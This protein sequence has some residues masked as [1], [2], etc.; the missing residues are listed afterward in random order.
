MLISHCRRR[1]AARCPTPPKLSPV[2]CMT[3]RPKKNPA[4]A[5]FA[6]LGEQT[7]AVGHATAAGIMLQQLEEL[8]AM[9]HYKS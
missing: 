3:N 7:V 6:A 8:L 2:L 1:F 9:W 4:H 5:A